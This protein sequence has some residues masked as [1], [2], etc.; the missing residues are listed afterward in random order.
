MKDRPSVAYFCM[1]YGLAEEMKIYAGGLGIL[2]G[3]I[4]KAARQYDYPIRGIGILWRQGYT[5][6]TINEK[7][8]PVDSYPR[9]DYIYDYL[10]DTGIK[11]SVTI[12]E[13]DV[14]CKVWKLDKYGNAP[15]Y[16]LDTNLEENSNK[17]ITGQLYGWFEEERIAQEIVLGIGGVKA[18]RKLDFKPDIYHFN[19]GHAVLAGTELIR[20]KIEAGLGFEDAYNKT[21]E[22]I[23]FTTHTPVEQGNEEH[24]FRTMKYMKAFNG[25]S[26][27]EMK[28][29][30]GEPFNMTATGLRLAK[31]ANGVSQLHRE[32]AREM[33]DHVD[34]SPEI[35][36]ITNG[37]HRDTWVDPEISEADE[38]EEIWTR[39]MQLK[40]DLIDYVED[41]SGVRLD[42]DKMIIG[43]ARR[44]APYKR[45]D[46]IF[47]DEEKIS[48][49]LESGDIQI[50]FSGKAHPL[51]D[52]GKKII[53]KLVEKT[54]EYPESVVFLEDYGIEI[55]RK[56]TR[57]SDVWL[58]NPRKPLEA[59][60]TSGMKA[61]M[62][63]VLNVSILD[64][65]WPEACEHGVNGWQFGDGYE[66][67]DQDRHDREALY[68]VLLD[69]VVP[70]YYDERGKW[71]EM[72]KDS[73]ESTYNEF[74]AESMLKS[75]YE[76]MYETTRR[77]DE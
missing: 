3:D 57:G 20:E 28:R 24:G 69:E 11:V 46:L 31:A 5:K 35:Q 65:W 10:E 54:E 44:A 49:Y 75:Y 67:E 74:S 33:W 27:S 7:G 64:G 42:E 19:E 21:R 48:P 25:L 51:D 2:A 76:N 43:F 6:Q 13:E 55:G 71:K 45:A 68:R 8:R 22:E 36:G 40:R 23:V 58:N 66:G 1:E 62:N 15:L 37:I 26:Q 14:S 47:S 9:N 29:I 63:G 59:S 61:A 4:L 30:G 18:L 72:S 52:T 70:T 39:H 50:V 32:T 16:L 41:K 73:I 60:G 38:K 56:L 12:R 34:E 77:E 53:R 17:W